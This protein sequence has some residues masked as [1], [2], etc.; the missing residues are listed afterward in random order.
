MRIYDRPDYEPSIVASYN[1]PKPL[2]FPGATIQG[3][4]MVLIRTISHWM[5]LYEAARTK[6]KSIFE[7]GAQRFRRHVEV[8]WDGVYGGVFCSLNNVDQ[9]LWSLDKVLWA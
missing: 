1:G 8:A 4:S 7:I 5:L 3:V 6:N 9:N 2:P